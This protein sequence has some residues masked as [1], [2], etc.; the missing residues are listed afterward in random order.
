MEKYFHFDRNKSLQELE[1][2]DLDEP[3]FDSYLVIT[4]HELRKKTI[5]FF[6]VE[7]LRIMIGQE[8]GLDYLIP[9]ALETLEDN[10]FSEGNFYC[11]DLL[12]SVLKV[13]KKFWKNNPIYKNDLEYLLEKN[14]KD[15][16]CKLASFH[17]RF[18]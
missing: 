10:I 12:D 18:V 5:A 11:G 14:I 9:L 16:A 8:I 3:N 13:D 6:E 4:C 17:Q 15:L 7:D 1:G 2:S